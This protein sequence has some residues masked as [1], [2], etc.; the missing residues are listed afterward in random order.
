MG[1][2]SSGLACARPELKPESY[3]HRESAPPETAAPVELPTPE[4]APRRFEYSRGTMGVHAHILLYASD[5]EAGQRAAALAFDRIAAWDR[6]LSDYNPTSELGRLEAGLSPGEWREVSPPLAEALTLAFR[7][8]TETSGAFDPT[9]GA[10]TRVWRDARERGVAPDPTVV[11]AAR[12]ATG[13]ALFEFDVGR[14]RLRVRHASARLDF[15]G[16]G[17]GIA[18]DSALAA[19]TESGCPSALVDLGGDLAIGAPPPGQAGWRIG[20]GGEGGPVLELTGCGI[21]TS[22]D[23]EQNLVLEG[24]RHSHILDPKEKKPLVGAPTVTIRAPTAA[25]ADA[26]ATALSVRPSLQERLADREGFQV[27]LVSPPDSAQEE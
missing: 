14:A 2:L 23:S 24:V 13:L 3:D 18:A 1:I 26:W 5:A 19:L 25:V 20:V 7:L 15:G 8:S 11:A 16:I 10:V 27:W 12:R 17:K 9:I 6:V 4:G 21:A 22:G